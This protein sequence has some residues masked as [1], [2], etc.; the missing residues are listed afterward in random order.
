[1]TKIKDLTKFLA[2]ISLISLSVVSP[3]F[4]ITT[5]ATT[6]TPKN[7]QQ[8]KVL[9]IAQQVSCT[10]SNIQTGQLALR[11][12]PGGDSRAGLDNGNTVV[13][14]RDGTGVWRYVRV[15]D[16][17][18]SDVNGLEGWVNSNYLTCGG[19]DDSGDFSNVLVFDPPSYIRTSPNGSVK[20]TITEQKV[21][22][23]YVEP[24]NGWYRT[25]ACGG[26]W[27][28]ESQIRALR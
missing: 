13:L 15:I 6:V 20:C 22:R 26:G 4:T 16:G 27:I 12:S 8:S 7:I 25:N 11:S 1:M 2:T 24:T 14:L 5:V 17:P 9:L 28:H 10:V 21:I 23:V 18:N 19:V 3:S